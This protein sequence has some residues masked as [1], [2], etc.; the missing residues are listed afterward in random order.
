MDSGLSPRHQLVAFPLT[1][2]GKNDSGGSGL[3]VSISCAEV[4]HSGNMCSD[5]PRV[6]LSK[7]HGVCEDVS[8]V[9]GSWERPSKAESERFALGAAPQ[10]L[11]PPL[12]LA[13]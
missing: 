11:G 10:K 12:P 7:G 3:A 1:T 9:V 13:E 6:L 8:T 4:F 5:F 2:S